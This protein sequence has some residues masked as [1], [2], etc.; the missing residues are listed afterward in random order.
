MRRFLPICPGL[1]LLALVV[2]VEVAPA[3][4]SERRDAVTKALDELEAW[5]VNKPGGLPWR[6]YLRTRELRNQLAANWDADRNV[7]REIHGR[8]AS[9]AAG[10]EMRRF[11]QVRDTLA[12]W[13]AD[14]EPPPIEALAELARRA[15]D[16]FSPTTAAEL[17]ESRR[18]LATD[19]AALRRY[20]SRLG[21]QRDHWEEFLRLD[22]LAAHLSA[23]TPP[24][25]A[26]LEPIYRR[27]ASGYPGLRLP[28]FSDVR[29][30]LQ[31][32]MHRLATAANEKAQENFAQTIDV[33]A[34]NL[35]QYAQK[36]SEEQLAIFAGATELL[37]ESGQAPTLVRSLRA[38]FSRPNLWVEVSKTLVDAGIGMEVDESTPVREFI[39]GTDVRG[40]GQTV[41][42]VNVE[43][44]PDR[45]RATLDAIFLGT[46]FTRT[47]GVNGPATI[48]SRGITRIGAR[49]RLRLDA[50]GL[51]GLPTVSAARTSTTTTGVSTNLCW[52]LRSVADR[53]AEKRVRESKSQANRIAARR[54]ERQFNRRMDTRASTILA[55]RTAGPL[56]RARWE[57]A[58]REQFPGL[59]RFRTTADELSLTVL[60][61]GRHQLGAPT[62]PP[63]RPGAGLISIRV[64]ESALNNLAT[65]FLSGLELEERQFKTDMEEVLGRQLPER[66]Q[67]EPGKEPWTITFERRRPITVRFS[68]GTLAVTI[69][70][71]SFKSG[72]D[73]YA[74][75]M[76][77]S[78]AY[79]VEPAEV[80][81]KLVRQGEAEIQPPGHD[82]ESGRRLGVRQVTLRRML[83]RRFERILDAE[84]VPEALELPEP[85]SRVGKLVVSKL[86]SADGWL[87]ATFDPQQPQAD[88]VALRS[89]REEE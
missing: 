35:A 39:L 16:D 36:P 29:S 55:E 89:R 15:R 49:K 23:S 24:D 19:V 12:A 74:Q 80:G 69:R 87:T 21:K 70:G 4:G 8:F 22:E 45:D 20:L 52:P 34:E 81:I 51:H 63:E 75:P 13:M 48:R 86:A 33:L 28:V 1:A 7:V 50:D 46:I 68:D 26:Q 43:L 56:R 78:F 72:E 82:P 57:L 76:N 31:A 40:T 67:P 6:Q 60:Q 10:L 59:L 17:E 84:I 85:W 73:Y 65:G 79:K 32:R 58:E 9:D 66:F 83:Q 41:G 71:R 88:T 5:L 27:F 37:E 14:L 53:V 18:R 64:H 25:P 2:L 62:A 38:H 47:V 42:R 61:A 54:A 3:Q 44:V 30:A 77:I 11:V